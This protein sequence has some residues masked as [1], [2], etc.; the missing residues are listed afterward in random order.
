MDG[1]LEQSSM[2]D[3]TRHDAGLLLS[4]RTVTKLGI[5]HGVHINIGGQVT[6]RSRTMVSRVEEVR[7]ILDDA[8]SFKVTR[9]EAGFLVG[10]GI[11]NEFQSKYGVQIDIS[12]EVKNKRRTV[13]IRGEEGGGPG[14]RRR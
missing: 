3:I 12:G 5:K 1:L 11:S 9:E 8:T 4:Q 7:R 13:V 2:I 14:L 6:D 10:G